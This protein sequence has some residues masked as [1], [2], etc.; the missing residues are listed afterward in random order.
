MEDHSLSN[1]LSAILA[2]FFLW[3]S[4]VML[5]RTIWLF[6]NFPKLFACYPLETY[7]LLTCRLLQGVNTPHCDFERLSFVSTK[8]CR[9][10]IVGGRGRVLTCSHFTKQ[11][12]KDGAWWHGWGGKGEG[13]VLQRVLRGGCT[14]PGNTLQN[15]L[16]Q[17]KIVWIGDDW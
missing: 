3:S 7:K 11:W 15:I 5:D 1:V 13:R 16:S 8:N 4:L 12:R 14:T 10:H 9:S 2:V 17:I 6:H